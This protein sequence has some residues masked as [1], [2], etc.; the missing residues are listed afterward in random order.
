MAKSEFFLLLVLSLSFALIDPPVQEVYDHNVAIAPQHVVSSNVFQRSVRTPTLNDPTIFL[1]VNVMTL[2]PSVNETVTAKYHPQLIWLAAENHVPTITEINGVSQYDQ[3]I[4]FTEPTII[5]VI[6]ESESS[7]PV[8]AVEVDENGNFQILYYGSGV[9]LVPQIIYHAPIIEEPEIPEGCER[10]VITRDYDDLEIESVVAY[11]TLRGVLYNDSGKYSYLNVTD[12]TLLAGKESLYNNP[13]DVPFKPSVSCTFL[14]FVNEYIFGDMID[15]DCNEASLARASPYA[16]GIYNATVR[17]LNIVNPTLEVTLAGSFSIFYTEYGQ[18]CH[19]TEEGC[20]CH[21]WEANGKIPYTRSD[22]AVY[23]VQNDYITLV[24][25]SPAFLNLSANISEDV[26]YYSTLFTNS[27]LYKYYSKMDGNLSSAYY[28]QDFSV[29]TDGYGIQHIVAEDLNHEGILAEDPLSGTNYTGPRR[30]LIYEFGNDLRSPTEI[31]MQRY[32]YSKSYTFKE[33][34]YNLTPGEHDA[35]LIFYTWWGEN[36]ANS[37][38]YVKNST[39]LTLSA[40]Q[41]GGEQITATCRLANKDGSPV[42]G[43]L[44]KLNLGEQI[45]Q[46]TT[47]SNGNCTALFDFTESVTTIS[48]EFSG[49]D[50]H[51]PSDASFMISI[52]RPFSPGTLDIPFGVLVLFS[53]LAG[54]MVLNM[55]SALGNIGGHGAVGLV[56]SKMFPFLPKEI[57]VKKLARVKKGK[58]LAVSAAMALATTGAGG[59]A[60][61]KIAGE[62]AKKKMGPEMEKKTIEKKVIATAKEKEKKKIEEKLANAA[63]DKKR[64]RAQSDD[65]ERKGKLATG[66]PPGKP[67]DDDKKPRKYGDIIDAICENPHIPKEIKK[68]IAEDYLYTPEE[69]MK[70]CNS[71]RKHHLNKTEDTTNE[72]AKIIQQK[73][74]EE[75]ANKFL[76]NMDPSTIKLDLPSKQHWS[77]YN[78]IEGQ[79]AEKVAGLTFIETKHI[80]VSPHL[81]E[82][83]DKQ[84]IE[85]TIEHEKNHI[86]SKILTPS[87]NEGFCE[88]YAYRSVGASEFAIKNKIFTTDP[89]YQNYMEI[90]KL[91]EDIVGKEEYLYSHGSKGDGHLMEIFDKKVN[92]KGES[93]FLQIFGVDGETGED[94]IDDQDKI[95][96]LKAHLIKLK[97]GGE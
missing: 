82:S 59:V 54:I 19:E 97:G 83:G 18:S 30:L 85:L 74:G 4:V 32:N 15:L 44:I 89:D 96:K 90:S 46:T 78:R 65:M 36:I 21:D 64:K 68:K 58:E 47:D 42:S 94:L 72:I 63:Y 69:K 22:F 53:L 9:N 34:F 41:F 35:D 26:I 86:Q 10:T 80:V 93:E 28:L 73:E 24:P 11:Y 84:Q 62:T 76:T 60:A 16:T 7:G 33:V 75:A 5:W 70:Q 51:M 92:A 39:F 29:V 1:Y 27:E 79:P 81:V 6:E 48:A 3:D 61:S 49:T 23:E 14:A 12:S 57:Q 20:E 43:A 40:F 37:D 88:E 45:I 67:G 13:A 71:L 17:N 31:N 50:T 77:V 8:S 91:T 25:Y 52:H 2:N 66:G 56:S 95:K 38:I 87:I 55:T